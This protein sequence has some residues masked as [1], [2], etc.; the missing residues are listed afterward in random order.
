MTSE[1]K[2]EKSSLKY[3]D[4]RKILYQ[5][6]S[7][8]TENSTEEEFIEETGIKKVPDLI[9]TVEQSMNVTYT[10]TGI[11]LAYKN[12]VGERDFLKNRISQLKEQTEK[13]KEMPKDIQELKEKIE[14]I[15]K[16]DLAEKAKVELKSIEERFAFIKKELREMK[17]TIGS[18]LKL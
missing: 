6:K 18:R 13:S 8:I 5:N 10:E 16:F 1:M 17:E 9:S 4:R 14:K 15:K 12:L 11:R 3:D 7:Q 2:E